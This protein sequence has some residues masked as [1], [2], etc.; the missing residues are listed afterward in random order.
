M[1]ISLERSHLEQLIERAAVG[2]L[3]LES[4]SGAEY[5]CRQN[6]TEAN[7]AL[8]WQAENPEDSSVL[9]NL[10]VVVNGDEETVYVSILMDG[11]AV[12]HNEDILEEWLKS[13]LF[14]TK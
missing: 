1:L 12:C 5:D 14:P 2:S 9:G 8:F 11:E 3:V 13:I 7:Q 10:R 6:H 4:T